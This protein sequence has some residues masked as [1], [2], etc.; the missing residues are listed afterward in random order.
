MVMASWQWLR[1]SDRVLSII[2][3]QPALSLDFDPYR[4]AF[5]S[6]LLEGMALQL[7]GEPDQT[8]EE[9][10]QAYEHSVA[11]LNWAHQ[12]PE[13][14]RILGFPATVSRRFV[15]LIGMQDPRTLV[16]VACFFAMTKVVDEVWWLKG[17]AKREV[18][19]ILSLLP[20]E[21]WGK[22]E[23]PLRIANHVG[24][25]DDMTWGVDETNIKE[26][27]TDA[28]VRTHIDMLAQL[29]NEQAPPMPLD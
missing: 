9:T 12:K 10:K 17:V 15:E 21:W 29:M 26:E 25:M 1:N 4:K 23:W 11:F 3:G 20:Q 27:E 8:R 7:L 28:D 16:I 14:A 19:G 6:P 24:D 2:S 5:F 22:M 13:R 18:N